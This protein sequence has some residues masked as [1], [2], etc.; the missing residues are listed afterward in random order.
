MSG[1]APASASP[2]GLYFR[3]ASPPPS[4]PLALPRPLQHS[5]PSLQTAALPSM[6]APK[7]P[8]PTADP[9][10]LSR[11]TERLDRYVPGG[12]N[13][14]IDDIVAV[15]APPS[16]SPS[17]STASTLSPLVPS[18]SPES[19]INLDETPTYISLFTFDDSVPQTIN[20]L[21]LNAPMSLASS[22]PI[23][24]SAC[25]ACRGQSHIH[26]HSH[27]HTHTNLAHSHSHI[28]SYPH[29]HSHSHSYPLPVA[30]PHALGSL[31]APGLMSQKTLPAS[32]L[33]FH[34]NP[35]IH[36]LSIHHPQ[37]ILRSDV[38]LP[39]RDDAMSIESASLGS[40]NPFKIGTSPETSLTV[41]RTPSE[42]YGGSG[43]FFL[44]LGDIGAPFS[45]DLEAYE[46]GGYS[47]S[48]MSSLAYGG[49]FPMNVPVMATAQAPTPMTT[50][51][52]TP[53][54]TPATATIKSARDGHHQSAEARHSHTAGACSHL[55]NDGGSRPC[56]QCARLKYMSRIDS[57][58]KERKRG[59]MRGSH[60]STTKRQSFT[61][62][63]T[64]A[65]LTSS[66]CSEG[67]ESE[68]CSDHDERPVSHRKLSVASL[69]SVTSAGEDEACSIGSSP[70]SQLQD[71]MVFGLDDPSSKA[72]GLG[73]GSNEDF[74]LFSDPVVGSPY[75]ADLTEMMLD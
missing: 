9:G 56:S 52:L 43:P 57:S 18:S 53:T 5:T 13:P 17:H 41:E 64:L 28:H 14:Y 46:I 35:S 16:P 68:C 67:E 48:D 73:F 54:L 32:S 3:F 38:H 75:M 69:G 71:D 15:P 70:L 60:I 42:L 12:I 39:A 23:S 33:H 62:D 27:T 49:A 58:R 59:A 8:Y 22:R 44:T 7:P 21:Q 51:T 29:P 6:S 1:P 47:A 72:H 10:F 36:P 25:A 4:L 50:P 45:S 26:T 40:P 34:P 55:D 20:P 66:D 31:Q 65:Y 11:L 37:A 61:V 63:R 19:S 74:L 24:M 30:H 2:L